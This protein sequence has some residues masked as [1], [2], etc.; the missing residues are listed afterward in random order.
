MN[1]PRL[2]NF[3]EWVQRQVSSSL[4]LVIVQCLLPNSILELVSRTLQLARTCWMKYVIKRYLFVDGF[5]LEVYQ[6]LHWK[7]IGA[8][9]LFVSG[10]WF[11]KARSSS[12]GIC[13]FQE[14][15]SKDSWETGTFFFFFF[16]NLWCLLITDIACKCCWHLLARSDWLV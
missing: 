14:G 16:F 11:I 8:M 1:F 3:S 13:S 6:S 9:V 10:C 4:I 2:L 5:S 12:N 7:L 15:Y